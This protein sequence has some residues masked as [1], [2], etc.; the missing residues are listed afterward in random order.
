MAEKN[1]DIVEGL[2]TPAVE[3]PVVA[4]G[5]PADGAIM[6]VSMPPAEIIKAAGEMATVLIDIVKAKG[7]SRVFGGSKEYLYFEAWQ[8]IGRFHNCT[9]VT[10]W[11][12]PIERKGQQR[13]WGW[14]CKVDVINADGQVIASAEGSCARDESNWA[15]RDD[16]AIRSM[17]QTRTA[18]K[19]LRSAFAW[20]AVLAG[21]EPTSAEEMKEEYEKENPPPKKTGVFAFLEEIQKLKKSLLK[22]RGN[23][24]GDAIYREVLKNYDAEKSNEILDRESQEAFFKELRA[25]VKAEKKATPEDDLP[26]FAVDPKKVEAEYNR[27]IKKQANDTMPDIDPADVDGFFDFCDPNKNIKN[28]KDFNN[29]LSL[30]QFE[31]AVEWIY[32]QWE[33]TQ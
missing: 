32:K 27:L 13:V 3:L 23:E 14:E 33:A 2:D 31:N 8:M 25:R 10:I 30:G 12:K 1:N 22:I 19:A 5:L 26:I 6:K 9:P 21:Y 28:D 18:G 7:L 16:Y 17:A 15:N 4:S 20:V 11:T 29:Y 24:T